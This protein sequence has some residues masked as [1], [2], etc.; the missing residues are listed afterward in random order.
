MGEVHHGVTRR[1]SG[2]LLTELAREELQ[3]FEICERSELRR[4]KLSI[5]ERSELGKN[6]KK[7]LFF[8]NSSTGKIGF[9]KF[10][11]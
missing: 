10:Y 6:T 2:A 1:E 3:I 8:E 11:I 9:K 5:Y 4:K 7:I